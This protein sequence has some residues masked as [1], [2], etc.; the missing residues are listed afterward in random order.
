MKKL[1]IGSAVYDDFEG[2]YF[3][4]QSLRLNNLDIKD[5][6]DFVIIDNNPDSAE[7]KATKHFCETTQC[8]RYIPFTEKRSTAVR[9]EIFNNAEGKFCMSIDCHVLFEPDTIK[10]LIKFFDEN[11]ESD[12]LYHGPMLYDILEGHAPVTHMNP[13]WR[14][15]M[16][17]TWGCATEGKG[18][19]ADDDPFEIP[20]HGLGIFASRTESWMGFN[21]DFIGFGGEEG[22]IHKKYKKDNRKIWCLPFL[23]WVHRFDRP[24]G[25]QYPLVI[26]ERIRNYLIG[27][28]ELELPYDDIIEHFTQSQPHINIQDIIDNLD[29]PKALEDNK[30][31]IKPKEPKKQ[32]EQ[33]EQ[34]KSNKKEFIMPS[35]MTTWQDSVIDF[36]SSSNFRY[37]RYEIL[38]SYDGH[39]ALQK[40]S[41]EP[42]HPK[43]IKVLT[44][45]SE[46]N[47]AQ[48]KGLIEDGLS[49]QSNTS[50]KGN[51]RHE[52]TLDLQAETEINKITT[53]ARVGLQAGMP[54]EFKV[55]ASNDLIQ[56]YEL[57][58]VNVLD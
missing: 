22:Y 27:H 23:R 45:S 36:T 11:P 20:M 6:L 44:F 53:F 33:K 57:S 46:S 55:Y 29:N 25:I 54:T 18:Y 38:N 12:D 4:Y 49:W 1:T 2:V 43:E 34:K 52:I 58:H 10:R 41:I 8:I 48:A 16:F 30:K 28:R 56:W 47:D 17:G 5:D 3:S 26:Q 50:E 40:F 51:Y 39:G 42:N 21:N 15:N 9:N 24:R 32:P 31:K 13:K 35:K 7:G 37:I 14:D 19:S